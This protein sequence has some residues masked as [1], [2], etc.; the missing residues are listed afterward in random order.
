MGTRGAFGV[1]TGE[2]EKIGYNQFDSY[3]DGKGIDNLRWLRQAVA[4]GRLDEI[5]QSAIDCKLVSNAVKPTPADVKHLAGATD[6]SVS[7]QSTDDWYCLTRDTHGFIEKMLDCGYIEDHSTFPLDSLFCEWAYIVDFDTGVFEVY[8]GFQDEA[9]T[10]GRFAGRVAK[11]DDWVP[12]YQGAKFYY[13]VRLVASYPLDALPSDEEFLGYFEL[14][15]ARETLAD[16]AEYPG[17]VA[18]LVERIVEK[19]LADEGQPYA[20][21]WAQIEDE[22]RKLLYPNGVRA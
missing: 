12:E 10:E 2:V 1:I 6:L 14:V 4:D 7:K 18:E 15:R 5:R 8:K 17:E 9:H 11:P 3:S 21:E 13:P 20:L 19:N 16:V 22:A